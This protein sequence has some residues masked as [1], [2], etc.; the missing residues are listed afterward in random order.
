MYELIPDIPIIQLDK[1]A[2]DMGDVVQVTVQS[3]SNIPDHDITEFY[4]KA[5]HGT[6]GVDYLYQ[7]KYISASGNVAIFSFDATRGDRY[8]TVEATAFD[9]YHN[10]G[11]LP[12]ELGKKSVYVKDKNPEPDTF[13]LDVYVRDEDTKSLINGAFVDIGSD[14]TTTVDG[15]ANFIGIPGGA[16]TIT[17]SKDGYKTKEVEFSLSADSSTTVY[18]TKASDISVIGII[19][20][21]LIFIAF[22]IIA[23]IP[24]I[25]LPIYGRI[26]LVI[27]GAALAVAIYFLLFGGIL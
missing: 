22:L 16:K 19:V 24:Q 6:A 12:S 15:V 14:T 18:L 8:I 4:V 9:G 23:L 20:S 27:L 17:V 3:Q 21:V 11:G 13:V 26:L 25:S 7:P 5:Y 10:Q 2:Y 1:V